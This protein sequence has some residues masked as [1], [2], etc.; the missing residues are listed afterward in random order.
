MNTDNK[1]KS[2]VSI[3]DRIL[4][5]I[6]KSRMM[7]HVF[8][9]RVWHTS[10]RRVRSRLF[11]FLAEPGLAEFVYAG[12]GRER[13]LVHC[14]DQVIGRELFISGQFEFEKVERALALVAA[15]R[16]KRVE[17]LVD[18]GANTGTVCIPALARGLVDQAIAIEPDPINSRL[19]R[20][21]VLLNEVESKIQI[22]QSAAGEHDDALLVLEQ[23]ADNWGDHRISVAG[24]GG[25]F[26]EQNRK[27]LTVP[28]NTLDK[29]V[30]GNFA[31]RQTLVWMDTQG[32]EGF[33]L[34]GA[35]KLLREQVP[36]VAEF[37]PYG[38]KRSG[39]YE[40]FRQS[41]SHYTGFIDLNNEVHKTLQPIAE[42]DQLFS[43]LDKD[44]DS[45][46]DVLVM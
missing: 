9:S 44:K 8:A 40:A 27:R 37:W 26:N 34:K 2:T 29:M 3:G 11:R 17:A 45:A 5:P 12:R 19:L 25:E 4:F 46:T 42:F 15:I 32:Y 14:K 10:E 22:H 21:N 16:G 31:N 18:V 43:R 30:P 39:S 38:F 23:S 24:D 36:V 41:L 7:L 20:I 6:A 13:Y 35:S 33:V 1:G 28:S